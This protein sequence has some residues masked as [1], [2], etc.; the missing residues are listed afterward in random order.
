VTERGRPGARRGPGGTGRRGGRNGRQFV[1]QKQPTPTWILV[2]FIGVPSLIIL[3]LGVWLVS[4]IVGGGAPEVVEKPEP[5][6]LDSQAKKLYREAVSMIHRAKQ[7]SD[8]GKQKQAEA[9]YDRALK[10]LSQAKKNYDDI[11]NE[12]K[13]RL[14][15]EDLPEDYRGFEEA[16]MKV[17][18]RM[19]DIARM[20]GFGI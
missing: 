4:N 18:Q 2:T 12:I 11:I 6:A 1:V 7:L 17:V 3:I 19:Q 8:S 5:T 13:V 20:K 15:V 10:K 16:R 14:G 9:I